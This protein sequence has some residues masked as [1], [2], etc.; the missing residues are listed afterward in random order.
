M[1]KSPALNNVETRAQRMA[2]PSILLVIPG[3]EPR[4]GPWLAAF[5]LNPF[6]LSADALTRHSVLV[7]A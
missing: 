7:G 4:S 3:I 1:I 2:I 5:K 6:S